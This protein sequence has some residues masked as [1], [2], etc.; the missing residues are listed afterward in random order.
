MCSLRS[1]ALL[2]LSLLSL[3]SVGPDLIERGRRSAD[4]LSQDAYIEW[5]LLPLVDEVS[6]VA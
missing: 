3:S 4:R 1:A 6:P 2:N 5:P